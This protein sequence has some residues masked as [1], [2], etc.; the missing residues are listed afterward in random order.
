MNDPLLRKDQQLHHFH[1]NRHQRSKGEWANQANDKEKR[2][3]S[4]FYLL[5]NL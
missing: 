4:T 2:Q 5:I 3:L 1:P